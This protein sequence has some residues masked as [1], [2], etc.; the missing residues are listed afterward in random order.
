[1][2]TEYRTNYYE[3][4]LEEEEGDLDI[5]IGAYGPV[6]DEGVALR[7]I[8]ILLYTQK[9]PV[10]FSSTPY[11]RRSDSCCYAAADGPTDGLCT[12]S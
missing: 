8:A 9:Y 3:Q 12:D 6:Y 2:A 1:M 5:S 10:I 7:T 11:D 4:E